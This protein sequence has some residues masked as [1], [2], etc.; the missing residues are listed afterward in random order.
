LAR[1]RVPWPGKSVEDYDET[2]V[3]RRDD[4]EAATIEVMTDNGIPG[5]VPPRL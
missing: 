4:L 1:E 5:A 3:F 2:M